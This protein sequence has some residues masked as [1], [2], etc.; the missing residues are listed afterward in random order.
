MA[1]SDKTKRVLRA[2]MANKAAADELSSAVDSG[3]NPQAASVALLGSTTNLVGTD[4]S[5][6]AG[7]AAPLAGTESRLDAAE[8]KIDAVIT[9]LKNAGLM[10]P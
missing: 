8:G 4:G 9:A 1:L 5:G 6:G 7:D 3:G 2:A 10:A